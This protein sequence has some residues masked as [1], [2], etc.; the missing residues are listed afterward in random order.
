M[1][2]GNVHDFVYFVHSQAGEYIEAS[3]FD[4]GLFDINKKPVLGSYSSAKKKFKVNKFALKK[5]M[6][7]WK[8][9]DA[10]AFFRGISSKGTNVDMTLGTG[11]L[12]N[13]A[14]LRMHEIN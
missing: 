6:E 7:G 1:A 8:E 4:R 12:G 9:G 14:G 10:G 5:T 13:K 3:L 2:V 11:P